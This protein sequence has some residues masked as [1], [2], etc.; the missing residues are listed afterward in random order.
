MFWKT[1]SDNIKRK[2]N[3][4][5]DHLNRL[6]QADY[7]KEGNT[8]FNSYLEQLTYDKNGNI[9]S[10]VR[11]GNMDTDGMQF[12][13][14]IDNLTYLYDDTNKNQL[15]RVFDATSNTQGF[16]DDTDGTDINHDISEAPD[17]RYDANGNMTEDKN[18]GIESIVYNHLN[19]P[20]EI[21]F[22]TGKITYLYNA[23]GQKIRKTV[24][25]T[26]ITTTTDYL[27]GFQYKNAVLQFFPHAEGYVNATES[28]V[29]GVGYIFNYVFNFTDHLGNIRLSYSKDPATNVLKIIEENHYYPFGLKHSGYNSDKLMYS[30]EGSTVKIKPMPPLFVTSY[31]KKFNGQS[32][33]TD[34]G[35]NITAMDYRQYDNA[36]GRFNSIDLLSEFAPMYSPYRFAFN[37]PVYWSDPS[38]LFETR[39][40]AREYRREHDLKGRIQRDG[41]GGYSIND[42]S[43][44]ISYFKPNE[45]EVG[46]VKVNSEGVATSA[47]VVKNSEYTW[48]DGVKDGIGVVGGAKDLFEELSWNKMNTSSK[49]KITWDFTKYIKGKGFNIST[50]NRVLYNTKIPKGLKYTGYGLAAISTAFTVADIAEKQEIRASHVLDVTM[51]GLSL[52]PGGGW[53]VGLTYFGLDTLTRVTTGKS[54][55]K[56]LDEAVEENFDKENGML[57]NFK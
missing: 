24:E 16:K 47:L 5:Y 13:N 43:N 50:K 42:K 3:Y 2:Y 53:I 51:T 41:N 44:N 20:V 7:S 26:S 6:L 36:L 27:S 39:K 49:S 35:I 19:L 38:G 21:V 55:G 57:I 8:T 4:S 40:E 28:T 12:E 31:D 45:D 32:W 37:N 54:I 23:V 9:Q 48:I 15:L 10:L 30:K 14:P 18:K 33:E 22:P 34:L 56:H 11:N 46:L 1:G 25:E 17:Y 52:I 29:K